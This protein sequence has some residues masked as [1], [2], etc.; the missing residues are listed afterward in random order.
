MRGVNEKVFDKSK[1]NP[2][3]SV[4]T[5]AR[6]KGETKAR[7]LALTR[8]DTNWPGEDRDLESIAGNLGF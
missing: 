6:K 1:H 4:F 8:Q 3:S 5:L 7:F 2:V